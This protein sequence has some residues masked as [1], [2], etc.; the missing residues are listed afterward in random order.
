MGTN[1]INNRDS[2]KLLQ[3]LGNLKILQQNILHMEWKMC[4]YPAWFTIKDPIDIL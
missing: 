1:D 4:L 2:C 3:L